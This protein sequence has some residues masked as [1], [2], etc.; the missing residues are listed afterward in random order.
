MSR[1]YN[2]RWSQN[3]EAELKRVVKNFNAKL[4]RLAK[5]DPKNQNALPERV[6]AANLK[7]MIQSRQ[8]LNRELNAL[9]RFSERGAEE[10][11]DIPD[12]YYNEKITKWQRTEMNRRAGQVNR[13]RK[14]RREKIFGT[15]ATDRG[16]PLG[17]SASV[18]MSEEEKAALQP[19]K[20]FTKFQNRADI[21]QKYRTLVKQSQTA[22]WN[23]RDNALKEGY[24][25]A[26]RQNLGTTA[27]VEEVIAHIENMDPGEFR[28]KFDSEGTKFEVAYPGNQDVKMENISLLRSIWLPEDPDD[29]EELPY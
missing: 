25:K 9:R 27:A 29:F 5:K 20:V 15:E 4:T 6:S 18:T 12:N 13:N 10:L 21:N 1:K 2:I 8:D 16:K 17:Y 28:K 14:I 23:A 19:I 26:L 24:I 11:V 22:Y 7:N 3:D